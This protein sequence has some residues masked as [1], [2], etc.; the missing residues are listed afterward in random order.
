[1]YIKKN[2]SFKDVMMFT[3][4]HFFW[5]IP[6]VT[7]IALIEKYSGWIWII[8]PWQ[9]V[10]IV[11][12]AVAFY[13]GFKN[14]Q[15]YDR[16]WEARKIWGAIVNSS[17][18]WS[19]SVSGFLT[20]QFI[21]GE[22]PEKELQERKKKLI[23]R[24]LAWLYSLRNQLLVPT[25]WEHVSISGRVGDFAEKRRKKLG[26]GFFPETLTENALKEYL[27][28]EEYEELI[29]CQNT[30]TNIIH[31]QSENLKELRQI[32][33][34]DDFRHMNLQRLLNEF[35]DHQGRLERIKSF[36]LPRQYGSMSF[37]FVGIF[38]SILPFGMIPLFAGLGPYSIF[39]AIPATVLVA[40]IY[41]VM[42]LVGDYSENPFEG[43]GND[44]PMLSLCRTIEIDLK[45]MLGEDDIPP[46]I[47]AKNGILM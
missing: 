31:T 15:S 13:L 34:I 21:E 7:I 25:P 22:I 30:A 3:G 46:A 42:E 1:M 39:I 8:L 47:K 9:P 33:Y 32:Q 4:H 20:S 38:I 26:I 11:G 14:N 43:L 40:W 29:N 28:E 36:P 45:E 41:L 24:H 2:F 18:A 5:M 12:T 35:Y 37:I 10:A 19:S 6:L 17:R 16:L 23:Y 44:I 27:P